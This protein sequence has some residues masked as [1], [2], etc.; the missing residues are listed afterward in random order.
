MRVCVTWRTSSNAHASFLFSFIYESLDQ[1]MIKPCGLVPITNVISEG[2]GEP[3]LFLQSRKGLAAHLLKVLKWIRLRPKN[4]DIDLR[5]LTNNL[6]FKYAIFNLYEFYLFLCSPKCDPTI[7]LNLM[8]H[9][10]YAQ[11]HKPRCELIFACFYIV[12]Y[13]GLSMRRASS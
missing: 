9:H 2:S 5:T 11:T 8:D 1:S 6:C 13:I 7:R 3:A 12:L 10:T 4:L